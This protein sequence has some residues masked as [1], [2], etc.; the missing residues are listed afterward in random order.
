MAKFTRLLIGACVAVVA[1]AMVAGP[2]LAL[3]SIQI[4][5][6]G[7]QSGTGVRVSFEEG[8]GFLRTVCEGLTL[9]GEGNERIPKRKGATLGLIT[10]GTTAG[11]RAFGLFA[12]TVRVEA[13]REAPF[14]VKYESI[15]GTLPIITGRLALTSGV[16]FTI[17]AAGRTC[18]YAGEAG[19]LWPVTREARGELTIQEANFLANPR[20]IVQ[21]GSTREC[22]REGELRGTVRLERVRTIKLV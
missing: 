4:S 17:E 18:R 22:P 19:A 12:A 21:E 10:S 8:G 14:T 7:A 6:P 16:K 15:L 13:T 2:A 5:N 11:C 1:L 20:A 3:R 9:N